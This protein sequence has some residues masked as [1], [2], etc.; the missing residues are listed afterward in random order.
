[1]EGQYF[2]LQLMQARLVSILL[3]GTK[4]KLNGLLPFP[5]KQSVRQTP[6]QESTKQNAWI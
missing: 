1:M 3:Y 6:D 2:P 5:W 4:Q